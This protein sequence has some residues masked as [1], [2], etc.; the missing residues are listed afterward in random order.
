MER[1]ERIKELTEELLYHCHLYYDLDAPILSDVEFD[2][3]CSEL[4]QLENEANF[5]LA[6]SPTR[7]VQGEVLSHLTK[8]R[9]SVPML[10]A[11]K[12]TNIEDVRKF[13]GDKFVVAS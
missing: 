4:E 10:S 8:V 9:H 5:W 3:R 6:N 1:I 11:A 2:R 12:S 13:I 7:K